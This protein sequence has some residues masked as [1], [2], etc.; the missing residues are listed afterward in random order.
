MGLYDGVMVKDN[1]IAA[2]GS[3]TEAVKSARAHAH[4]LVRIEVE[5][6][7][8]LQLEE[9]LETDADVILLD[10]MSNEMLKMAVELARR[11][12]PAVILEAS[13]NMTAARVREIQDFGLDLVSAGA[14]IHQATWVDFSM[15]MD[16]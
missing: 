7:D 11:R 12:K 1:H 6:A 16:G 13:G 14:L 9:A 2:V 10:N 8:L 15:Q 5:V 3:L 4:H